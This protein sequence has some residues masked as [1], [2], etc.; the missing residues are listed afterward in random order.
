MAYLRPNALERGFN[1]VARA[2]KIGGSV[3]LTVAKR[4]G[5]PPLKVPVIL[6]QVDGATYLVST[7]GEAQWVRH[8]RAANGRGELQGIGAFSCVELPTEERPPV[9]DAYRT[10]AGKVV[11][12]YFAQLP[13]PADHP[14][15]RVEPASAA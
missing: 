8:L 5:G 9:I 14:V 7:R 10:T 15:F 2:A 1:R 3:T 4:G 13:D 11:D 6:A 12:K